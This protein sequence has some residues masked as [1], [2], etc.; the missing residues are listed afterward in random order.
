MYPTYQPVF[1]NDSY[2]AYLTSD[3][4][5]YAFLGRGAYS[6]YTLSEE[7]ALKT[8]LPATFRWVEKGLEIF[9]YTVDSTKIDI[10]FDV[11]PGY[12]NSMPIR[13]VDFSGDKIHL[14]AEFQ[15]NKN[16]VHFDSIPVTKGMNCFFIDSKDDV[17]SL[18][19]YGAL[20]REN[21]LMD[22]RFLNFAVGNMQIQFK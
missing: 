14:K 19:R 18:P 16:R 12:V 3:L 2:A 5:H 20:F 1:S 7:Q 4:N 15:K 21:V 9:V 11:A 22:F 13:S 8:G 17:T 6:T 10:Q